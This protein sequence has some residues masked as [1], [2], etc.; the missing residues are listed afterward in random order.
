M[1]KKRSGSGDRS[2]DRWIHDLMSTAIGGADNMR[3][4]QAIDQGAKEWGSQHRKHFP[5]RSIPEATAYL[6][7]RDVIDGKKIDPVMNAKITAGHMI[8]DSLSAK[9]KERMKL[10]QQIAGMFL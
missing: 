3:K 1:K 6:M 4:D 7:W 8:V 2:G 10:L 9:M 5:H